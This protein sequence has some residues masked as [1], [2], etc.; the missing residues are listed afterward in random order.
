L[1]VAGLRA[2]QVL[3]GPGR[4]SADEVEVMQVL[5]DALRRNAHAQDPL[6]QPGQ[7]RR[8]PGRAADAELTRGQLCP[9]PQEVFGGR[10]D[11]GWPARTGLLLQARTALPPEAAEPTADSIVTVVGDAGNLLGQVAAGGEEDHLGTQPGAWTAA[12]PQELL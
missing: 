7:L 1:R 6:D 3:D 8:G 9:V 11:L 4:S 2:G 12:V 5:A 10:G